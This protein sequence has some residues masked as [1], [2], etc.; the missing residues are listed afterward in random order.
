MG[1]RPSYFAIINANVRY[2][3]ELTPNAKLLYG[4]ITALSNKYGFCIATNEY[5]SKLYNVSTRTITEW[6]RKLEDRD[7]IKTELET[8]RYEDGTV[9]KIRKIYI[10]HIEVLRQDQV[11]DLQ[12]DQVEENFSYNSTIDNNTSKKEIYKEKFTPPTLEEVVEYCK[13]RN[14]KIDAQ[15]FIDYYT[16]I[17]WVYGKNR[18]PIK[19]WKSCVRTWEKNLKTKDVPTWFNEEQQIDSASLEEQEELDKLLSEI[20]EG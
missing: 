7:Y 6:I 4:E 15:Y 11:E 13:E 8:K 19:D 2:D 17:G 1:E 14:N 3:S 20:T 18:L 9:K 16:R 10:D 12:Q 5:F